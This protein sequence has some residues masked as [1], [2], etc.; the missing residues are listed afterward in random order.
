MVF[1]LQD[2]EKNSKMIDADAIEAPMLMA[3]MS[4]DMNQ[5]ENQTMA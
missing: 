1:N 3:G 4:L 2:A 5:V